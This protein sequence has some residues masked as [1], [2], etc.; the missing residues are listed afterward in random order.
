L[1]GSQLRIPQRFIPPPL[2]VM[3]NDST[4]ININRQKNE[5]IMT[6]YSP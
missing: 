4:K 3:Q 5:T 2:A 6:K 1:I